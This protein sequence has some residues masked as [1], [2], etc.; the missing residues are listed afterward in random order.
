M[1]VYMAASKQASKHTHACVQCNPAS[2][3][4]AR[5]GSPQL[6]PCSLTNTQDLKQQWSWKSL[7][8]Y[9]ATWSLETSSDIDIFWKET[10]TTLTS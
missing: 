7:S 5:S 3:H 2:V 4:G 9:V 8:M 10:A 1:V 6:L